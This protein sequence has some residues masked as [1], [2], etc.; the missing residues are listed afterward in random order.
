MGMNARTPWFTA[1]A[2]GLAMLAAAQP[3]WAPPRTPDGRP[4]LQGIWYFGSATSLERPKEFAGKPVLT[5]EEAAAFERREADRIARTQ[6]VHAPEW[7]DYGTKVVPDLRSSL[8]IDP[9]DGRVP[10]LTPEARERAGRRAALRRA[11]EGPEAFSSNERCIVFGAGPPV[12]PGPMAP[13]N[14]AWPNWS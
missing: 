14:A 8:I 9:P 13:S 11:A 2:L 10:P 1:A 4:D 5:A 12:L 6:T 3:S 7:L